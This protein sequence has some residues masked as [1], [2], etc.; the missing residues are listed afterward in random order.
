MTDYQEKIKRGLSYNLDSEILKQLEIFQEPS[1]DNMEAI[2][3]ILK[4]KGVHNQI[5]F[6]QYLMVVM[7]IGLSDICRYYPDLSL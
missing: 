7:D 4:S 1:E 2:R 3:N 6:Y 5:V